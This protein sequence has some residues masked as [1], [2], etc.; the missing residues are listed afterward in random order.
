[1]FKNSIFPLKFDSF[2]YNNNILAKHKMIIIGLEIMT[3]PL[4]TFEEI[5]EQKQHKY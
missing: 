4:S 5:K 2:Y 3:H 1:M